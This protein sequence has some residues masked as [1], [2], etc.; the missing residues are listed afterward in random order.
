MAALTRRPKLAQCDW[1]TLK[2]AAK[3]RYRGNLTH[4]VIS[5]GGEWAVK[6]ELADMLE[7]RLQYESKQEKAPVDPPD[8]PPRS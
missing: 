1:S 5:I 3:K 6:V 4:N 2:A 7:D 8:A